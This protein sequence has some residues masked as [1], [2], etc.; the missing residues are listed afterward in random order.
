VLAAEP[1]R[2][3]GVLSHGLGYTMQLEVTLTGSV[4]GGTE[5]HC[6]LDIYGALP[7]LFGFA[8]DDFVRKFMSAYMSELERLV[9]EDQPNR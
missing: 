2:R 3:L 6:A 5:V 4:R 1:G 9:A 8:I 7:L